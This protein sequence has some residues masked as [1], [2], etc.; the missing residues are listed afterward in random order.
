MMTPDGTAGR[1]GALHSASVEQL[2]DRVA[3]IFVC[4]CPVTDGAGTNVDVI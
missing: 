3:R 2:P 1:D 4:P